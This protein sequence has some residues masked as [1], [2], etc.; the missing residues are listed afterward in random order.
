MRE[1]LEL[2]QQFDRKNLYYIEAKDIVY[3]LKQANIETNRYLELVLE[4]EFSYSL[5]SFQEFYE[6]F[7]R[8]KEL[9]KA[10]REY[11]KEKDRKVVRFKQ[12]HEA[13]TPSK[14]THKTASKD[15]PVF[16]SRTPKKYHTISPQR[17]TNRT[18]DHSSPP[19]D[20]LQYFNPLDL[21]KDLFKSC[22][23]YFK[24]YSIYQ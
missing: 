24:V 4:K 13:K 5:I 6:F 21:S 20:F 23:R 12:M 16:R 8:N 18:L 10:V 3:V 14:Q 22:Q 19:A 9:V 11:G 2:F 17:A 1:M 15:T 7:E